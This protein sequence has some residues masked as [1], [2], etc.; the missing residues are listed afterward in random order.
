MVREISAARALHRADFPDSFTHSLYKISP[1]RGCAHGCR[2]CDGRA[3][4]YFVEGDFEKEI[5]V[6]TNLPELLAQELPKLKEKGLV[7]ISSGT[8]DPYQPIERQARIVRRCG[9]LLVEA[10]LPVSI[11]TKSSLILEDLDLWKRAAQGAGFL[12]MV[13]ISTMNEKVR[14]IFEPGASPIAERLETLRVFKS[15]GAFTGALVMPFLPGISDH[16]EGMEELYYQLA[17]A[18]VNFAMPGGL[19]L[20]PGRQKQ[21]Y[22]ET[23]SQYDPSLMQS[24]L[25]HYREERASGAPLAR[26]QKNLAAKFK[27]VQSKSQIPWI[28]PYSAYRELIP[29][30]DATRI[31]LRDLVELYSSRQIGTQRLEQVADRYDSWL[32]AQRRQ[33]RRKRSLPKDYLESRF[34]EAFSNGELAVVIKNE[35]LYSFLKKIQ[36][37]ATFNYLTVQLES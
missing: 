3:E 22:L 34:R 6:R 25:E 21:C 18:G 10:N 17:N 5:V 37:G 29:P 19:T 9:E 2:Y 35:K 26:A 27:K 15:I 8:T 36:L 31:F 14:E 1:F 20:R 24:T 30:H 4:R 13:S 33:F 23:L 28:L 32:L 7:T 11:M 16:E 12:L